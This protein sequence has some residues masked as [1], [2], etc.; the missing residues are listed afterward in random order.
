MAI[1]M[2]I[3]LWITDEWTSTATFQTMILLPWSTLVINE[4]AARFM[5][6]KKPLGKIIIWQGQSYTIIG[7]IK[8]ML[9]ESP[10]DPVRPSVFHLSTNPGTRMIVKIN[11]AVNTSAALEKIAEVFKKYSPAQPFNYEFADQEYEKK[12]GDEQRMAR[13]A[14]VFALLAIFI[15]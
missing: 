13:I 9:A 5:G 11:P 8:D 2:L 14:G 6:M 1:A 15:S 10:Y 4:T 12:F 7:V 3:G